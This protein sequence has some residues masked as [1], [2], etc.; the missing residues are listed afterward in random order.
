MAKKGQK[1]FTDREENTAQA[2]LACARFI[3][4]AEEPYQLYMGNDVLKSANTRKLKIMI[5][6]WRRENEE[7]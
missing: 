1:K 3:D 2:M 5:M 6:E 4:G 7:V